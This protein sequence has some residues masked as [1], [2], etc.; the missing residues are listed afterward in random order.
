MIYLK[1]DNSAQVAFIP[2]DGEASAGVM[3][4]K[5]VSTIN[6]TGFETEV[7]DVKTSDLFYRIAVQLPEGVQDGEYEY[8]LTADEKIL[9]TGILI[10]GDVELMQEYNNTITYEQY[11]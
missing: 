11:R 7:I 5:A 6:L 3:R 10:I 2:K 1:S 8:S 4:L 9:S